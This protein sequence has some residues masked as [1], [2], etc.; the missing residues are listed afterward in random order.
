MRA[1]YTADPK[2]TTTTAFTVHGQQAE[3]PISMPTATRAKKLCKRDAEGDIDRQFQELPGLVD[4]IKAQNPGTLAWVEKGDDNVFR[5]FMLCPIQ[6]Q[7]RTLIN[8][9][10]ATSPCIPYLSNVKPLI[11]AACTFVVRVGHADGG[12]PVQEAFVHGCMPHVVWAEVSH[13][14]IGDH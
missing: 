9:N 4:A 3:I 6:C 8:V 1:T 2:N 13:H 14:H 11:G 10:I 12:S 5:R 7:V